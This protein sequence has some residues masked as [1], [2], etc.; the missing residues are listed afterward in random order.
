MQGEPD[1]CRA[2][3]RE[4]AIAAS[5]IHTLGVIAA[6]RNDTANG[7]EMIARSIELLR[8]LPAARRA[9]AAP[10]GARLRARGTRGTTAPP[11]RFLEQ[12]FVTAR[13]VHPAG[14]VAYALC[15][16]AAA[17]RYAGDLAG[18]RALLE[19]SLA[20]F[21]RLGDELGAAQALAQLGNLLSA[22]G[23]HELAR[24]LHEESLAV[25]EAANDAR[26]IGL[27]LLA[28]AVAAATRR[29]VA[30][31]A[32]ASAERALALF[33]R[34]DDGPG[35]RV[36]RHAA[37]IPGRRRQAGYRRRASFRSGRSRCGR[38]FIP[39]NPW[40]AAILLELADL[41]AALGEP[42]PV[43]GR[44]RAGRCDLRSRSVTVS[45]SPTASRR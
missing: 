31:R 19:E 3:R 40:C 30:S 21:R 10:G 6:S 8:A 12:T 32:W 4:P 20:L 25:R 33:D 45:A 9:P 28:I 41:D 1:D 2:R 34:T 44:L 38:A 37:G 39:N 13:R 18:S 14:A 11:R 29:G 5:V 7:R 26:G 27:S 36:R 15:D 42:G 23:E 24:E 17:A 35:P 16:L 43:P 22:D